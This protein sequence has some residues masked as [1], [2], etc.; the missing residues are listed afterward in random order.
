MTPVIGCKTI[1]FH[2]H[3]THNPTHFTTSHVNKSTILELVEHIP[4]RS[5]VSLE[6]HDPRGLHLDDV[7][8]LYY[9]HTSKF[10]ASKVMD[11]I[12]CLK[13]CALDESKAKETNKI[14]CFEPCTPGER[15]DPDEIACLEQR[16][17]NATKE[18]VV[19][20]W[21]KPEEN[22]AILADNEMLWVSRDKVNPPKKASI[23]SSEKHEKRL[24]FFNMDSSCVDS[25][26]CSNRDRMAVSC[27][28]LLVKRGN[29]IF[30]W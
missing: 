20:L 21:T 13:P 17:L 10:D 25:S 29:Q 12:G 19:G 18:M 14:S 11:Q 2:F 4:F 24:E 9:S 8:K 15:K 1:F 30:T 7:G 23:I 27:P 28:V 5:V 6:V 16:V 26:D 3:R 22:G